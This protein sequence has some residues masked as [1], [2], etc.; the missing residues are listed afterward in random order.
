MVVSHRSRPAAWPFAALFAAS[1]VFLMVYAAVSAPAWL[2]RVVV[3]V[4]GT[5]LSA[6]HALLLSLVLL[7]L[8]HGLARRRRVAWLLG[9]TL[10]SWSGL[11]ELE[12]LVVRVPG[13]PWRLVP[14]GL[15]IVSL[16]G[17]RDG[18]PVLPDTH[19]IRQTAA[20]AAASGVTLLVIGGGSLF[21]MRGRF[22][23]PLSTT[24]LG[25]EFVAAVAANSGPGEFQGPSWMLPGLALAGGLA[26]IT[27]LAVLSAAAPPPEPAEPAERSVVR[28]LVAHPDSDTLAPF[29]LRYDKTY[30]FEPRGRAAVGY[31]VLAGAAVVGGDPVGARDA[32]PAAID[33]FLAEAERR[34]WRPA[35]LGAGPEALWMWRERGMRG[36]GIGDEVIVDVVAYSDH[37][38]SMRNVRQAVKR[39]ENAGIEVAVMP[40]R[41]LGPDLSAQLRVIYRDWLGRGTGHHGREHGFAMN[42]D[43]MAEGR[44]PDALLAI[45][46]APEG[47]AVSFQRYLPTGTAGASPAL[48]LDV[49]PR[50][51]LAPNGVN[52]RLIV[53][54]VEYAAAHGY[55]A[56]SLNF[57][58]FRTLLEAHRF[59]PASL[60]RRARLTHRAIH[61]LDPL[62]QVESLYRFN[63]KFKPDWLPRAI[64]VQSWLD[65][66]LFA[67]AAFGLEFALP[68]DRRHSRPGELRPGLPNSVIHQPVTT[69]DGKVVGAL[70]HAGGARQADRSA[71]ALFSD[72]AERRHV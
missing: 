46:F 30:V 11:T 18:F 14:L 42:L 60:G 72:S 32:W 66:P 1:G 65:L 6:A 13:E 34:G 69:P 40:E 10:V 9:L 29:A 38:R 70:E 52:E 41:E 7:T 20:V 16:L 63:A 58:A 56:V 4:C 8:A 59:A 31:R 3:T 24:D 35:V 64:L 19:R 37:G 71:S 33:A 28:S 51:R 53:A 43:A 48:S 22:S 25:R 54:T 68:Y 44:H 17:A 21:V 50:D 23:V 26:L 15:A 2:G 47:Y 36:F 5:T 55:S 67:L 61:L 27:V 39:T 49:M 62:I 12:A 45:A 57:A